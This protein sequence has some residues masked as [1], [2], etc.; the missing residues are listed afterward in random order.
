MRWKKETVFFLPVMMKTKVTCGLWPCTEL[1]ARLISLHHHSLLLQKT[2]LFQKSRVVGVLRNL[3]HLIWKL[4]SKPGLCARADADRAR[5][6]GMEEYISADPCKFDHHNLFKSL[7]TLTLDFRLSDPYCSLVSGESLSHLD[8][9]DFKRDFIFTGLVQSGTTIC[10]GWILRPIW[11]SRL[12]STFGVPWWPAGSVRAWTHDWSDP[13]TLLV[14]VL[15][16]PCARQQVRHVWISISHLTI[17]VFLLSDSLLS[18][19]AYCFG[20]VN[21]LAVMS[22]I[23][24]PLKDVPIANKYR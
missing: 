18:K 23:Y 17:N 14:C 21:I 13:N 8:F 15:R 22:C 1:Q 2:P 12:L 6:H 5:K 4:N 20:L 11:C 19:I 16:I 9:R 3:I 10:S 24:I 7:Q